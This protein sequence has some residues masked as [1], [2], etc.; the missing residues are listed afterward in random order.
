MLPSN[1]SMPTP[2]SFPLE[3]ALSLQH[4]AR[5]L[6]LYKDMFGSTWAPAT[7]LTLCWLTQPSFIKVM[8]SIQSDSPVCLF[9][10]YFLGAY[11]VRS[12]MQIASTPFLIVGAKALPKGALIETQV[13]A[14]TGRYIT[15]DLDMDEPHTCAAPIFKYGTFYSFLN[16]DDELLINFVT[17]NHKSGSCTIR[18]QRSQFA[19]IDAL[20]LVLAV[21]GLSSYT[22]V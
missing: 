12:R 6:S 21:K 9:N 7:Q 20:S 3:A 18:W 11:K 14:H 1:L 22:I 5:I 16:F 2:P 17:G 10:S 19:E 13:F 4:A 15:N 8:R